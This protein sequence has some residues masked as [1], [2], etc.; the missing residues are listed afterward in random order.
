MQDSSSP[1]SSL[2]IKDIISVLQSWSCPLT[3]HKAQETPAFSS[4]SNIAS[5]DNGFAEDNSVN[6]G[7]VALVIWLQ[8][9][10][11]SLY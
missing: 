7:K 4:Q 1:S 11:C 6:R 5:G 10:E 8:M 9:N 2:V 3:A